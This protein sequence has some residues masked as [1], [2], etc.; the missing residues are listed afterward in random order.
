[1]SK[2]N[3]KDLFFDFFISSGLTT[4]SFAA[5]LCFVSKALLWALCILLTHDLYAQKE[6]N[7]WY[8]GNNAGID[9]SSGTPT[10]LLNSQMSAVEGCASI[11]DKR[12]R[13]LFYTNGL[14][15]WD[16]SHS[17]MLNGNGLKGHLSSTQ[18]AI[19]I[20]KPG[21]SKIYYI[22]TTDQWGIG[23]GLNYS[24]LDM[25]LNGGLGAINSNKNINLMNG[26]TSEKLTA[27]QHA[28]GRDFWVSTIK[29][30]SDTSYAYLL[31]ING[32]V[33]T[34]VKSVFGRNFPISSGYMKYSPDGRFVAIAL[35]G[36]DSFVI[37]NFNASN[38]QFSNPIYVN[39]YSEYGLEFSP[40]SR[41]LYISEANGDVFQF[42]LKSGNKSN[43]ISSKTTISNLG[44]S[45][46]GAMQIGP[47]K[48]IYHAI[49]NTGYLNL[50]QYPD[51][52]GI[53]CNYISNAVYLGGRTCQYGL[54]N[55]LPSMF[56][57][58]FKYTRNCIHDSV[59]FKLS[60]P[61][62]DSVHW[63][64]GDSGS[65]NLNKSTSVSNAGH[66]YKTPG[67]YKVTLVAFLDGIADTSIRE[68]PV[69]SSKPYIGRDTTFCNTSFFQVKL[70]PGKN[71]LSYAWSNAKTT[72]SISIN[73]KGI[74]IVK[75]LDTTGCIDS[76]TMEVN[77]P[78]IVAA[79]DLKDIILCRKSA[80]QMKNASIYTEDQWK[81]S[82]FY[83][84]DN[85]KTIDTIASKIFYKTDSFRI[86]MVAESL[87]GCKDSITHTVRTL[88]NTDIAFTINKGQQ[89]LRGNNFVFTNQSAIIG[90]SISNY[91]WDF[92]D[93]SGSI[94]KNPGTKSYSKDSNYKVTLYTF[95]KNGCS[96][97]L[98]KVM[99]V[100]PHPVSGFYVN[101]VSQ[102][103]RSN[104]FNFNNTSVIR[105]DSISAYAWDMGNTIKLNNA[106]VSNFVYRSED[107]FQ[108]R[109]VA[110]S[111]KGCMDTFTSSVTTF[112]QPMARFTVPRDSQCWN[113]HYFTIINQSAIKYGKSLSRWNFGDGTYDSAF[114]PVNKQYANS[115]AQYT[116]RY[117][118]VSEH[119]CIDS[120]SQ[121]VT[122]IERPRAVFSVND[123]VQ[124]LVGNMFSFVN[125]STFSLAN[126]LAYQWDY[127]NGQS[128]AGLN[129][130]NMSYDK[131]QYYPVQLVAYSLLSNCSDTF[132]QQVLAAPHAIPDFI[133]DSDS[134]CLRF[135]QFTLTNKSSIKFGNIVYNWTFNDGTSSVLTDPIKHYDTG[136]AYKVRLLV[137][138]DRTCMDSIEKE[139]VL[140]P[141]P[142]AAFTVNDS[143]QCLNNHAF[144]LVNNG[145]IAYGSFNTSWIFDDIT[146]DSNKNIF[147]KQFNTG[148]YHNILLS[149]YSSF[150]C[151]DT[152]V[153]KVYL[154]K[155][156]NAAIELIGN[157]SQCLKGNIFNMFAKSADPAILY[158]QVEWNFAD[159]NTSDSSLALNRYL[160]A[161]GYSILLATE[162]ING[163][164]DSSFLDIMVHPQPL[165]RFTTDTPC[166]PEPVRF[167]NTS[168][169]PVG[170]INIY[171][172]DFGDLTNSNLVNPLRNYLQ[173]G[174]YAVSLEAISG[175]G[176][177]DTIIKNKGALVRKRPK[178]Y[179]TYTRM[180]DKQALVSTLKF[181]NFSSTDVV[182]N[183]WNFEDAGTSSLKEPL[184]D[185]KD[186]NNRQVSL[187][188]KNSEGCAD[189][190][191]I[192][193][194]SLLP[195]FTLF[196]PNAFSPNGNNLNE[197]YKP[198]GALYAHSYV[199]EIFNRW[200]EKVF[201][202]NDVNK[203]WD[204]TFQGQNCEEGVFICRLYVVPL[205]GKIQHVEM[206]FHLLR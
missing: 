23:N 83:F 46:V 144:D 182:S 52:P 163:C 15:V 100:S 168:T 146:T 56:N 175:Y 43:I 4:R 35:G 61:L 176:C 102:C 10:A 104:L 17:I 124:C 206:S 162:S 147:A 59:K 123:S 180:Q 159:G 164:L 34:P 161:G 152:S 149:L 66:V 190:F 77:N 111:D 41:Y 118:L 44:A 170:S 155:N 86:K 189:T 72:Q 184:V 165:A 167:K 154:E 78:Q 196:L 137:T 64:F 142:K 193:T 90:D 192:N 186:S 49:R 53:K 87:L 166:F 151:A 25:T 75:T 22:F 157:D 199:M 50:I 95:A 13:L 188:V 19:I 82:T 40:S 113:Q 9:F 69:V 60:Y 48:K 2:T 148:G 178:A 3:R 11:A 93:G 126:S 114:T 68:V 96:D 158:N 14:T 150:N 195:D 107:T 81:R 105:H 80:F 177:A 36:V 121:R 169:I 115:S 62:V 70:A 29:D 27:V 47:D 197:E 120:S 129:A 125:L 58:K 103:F 30:N 203:G 109:L 91:L 191:T 79:F 117:T 138:T 37:C 173:P 71:F 6:A 174:A 143:I 18:S 8:L 42:D 88:P 112:A 135:N 97:T 194:G 92:G 110:I 198:I 128:S 131:G 200:G 12:G 139:L 5:F 51:S 116:I 160:T 57:V 127:G 89:C 85:S 84:P 140:L 134:Q 204:G 76:D 101:K 156:K 187:T 54:P 106:N 1:M 55:I 39:K 21:N 132:T 205:R 141:H 98:Q 99:T 73:K 153:Q 122:L 133:V 201:E 74:Y 16:S 179:F 172:W 24:E 94:Q 45:K 183:Q 33:N 130:Q 65:G 7:K 171:K 108:V 181:N 202:T 67:K 26:R 20:P 31:T 32:V 136:S 185:F 63:D 145:S 38:G 119:G 28:N